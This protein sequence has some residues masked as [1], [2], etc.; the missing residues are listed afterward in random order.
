MD[1][2]PPVFFA[3]SG[4]PVEIFVPLALAMLMGLTMGIERYVRGRPAG[5]RTYILVCVSF[6]TI[7]LL[8]QTFFHAAGETLRAD[9]ARL[10][11]GGVTG[12]WFLGAWG[13]AR[14]RS[15]EF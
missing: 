1:I 8:S 9:P 7:G 4:D 3:Y 6:T 10:A 11:A 14:K 13:M 12:V 2:V 15:E 5:L